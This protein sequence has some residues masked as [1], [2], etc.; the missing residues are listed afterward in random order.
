MNNNTNSEE[1]NIDAHIELK[2]TYVVSKI[3]ES[4]LIESDKHK[5]II[6]NHEAIALKRGQI[7]GG[8]RESKDSFGNIL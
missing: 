6:C 1:D 5:R 7:Y 4:K 3:E 2:N 8:L